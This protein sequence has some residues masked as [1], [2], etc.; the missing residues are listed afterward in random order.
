MA[1]CRSPGN[2]FQCQLWRNFPVLE[3]KILK[4]RVLHHASVVIPPE[5]TLRIR[6]PAAA[7]DPKPTL[8]TE[9][10]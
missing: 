6:L 1:D 5:Q 2:V 7:T 9:I 4:P 8:G 3:G 10:S